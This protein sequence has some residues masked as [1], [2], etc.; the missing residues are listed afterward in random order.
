MLEKRPIE[1]EQDLSQQGM[2]LK[3]DFIFMYITR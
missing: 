2:I 3:G 1:V